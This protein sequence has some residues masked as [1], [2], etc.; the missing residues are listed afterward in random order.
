LN[1]VTGIINATGLCERWLQG[2]DEPMHF[3]QRWH[4]NLKIEKAAAAD[5]VT[6]RLR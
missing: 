3:H 2:A 5:G 4:G 1:V 6:A